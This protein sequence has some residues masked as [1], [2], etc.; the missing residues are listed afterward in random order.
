VASTKTVGA[1]S[2][3]ACTNLAADA[4]HARDWAAHH[5]VPLPATDNHGTGGEILFYLSVGPELYESIIQNIGAAQLGKGPRRWCSAETNL[6]LDSASSSRSPLARPAERGE[7]EPR[8]WAA[9]FDDE[10]C[11]ASITT[12][13]KRRC[14]NLLV[15]RFANLLF[16]RCGTG[17]TS[18]TYKSRQPRPWAW[19]V[20]PPTTIPPGPCADMI[21]SHLL[22]LM[23][24]VAMEPPHLG[25]AP[26]DLRSEQRHVLEA[27]RPISPDEV[28]RVAVRAQY[29]RAQTDGAVA[30]GRIARNQ[31]AGR[32]LVRHICGTQLLHRQLAGRACP[33]SA[34]GQV[35]AAQAHPSRH[36]TSNRPRSCSTTSTAATS[37]RAQTAWSSTVQP[38]RHQPALRRQ[39]SPAWA[40][41]IQSAVLDSTIAS[42]SAPKTVR[43]LCD[44]AAGA[45]HGTSRTT[46]IVMRS[47]PAWRIVIAVLD[48]WRDIRAKAWS[49]YPAEVGT[50]RGR[51][52]DPATR[53]LAQPGDHGGR[54]DASRRLARFRLAA[55]SAPDDL[56]D[57]AAGW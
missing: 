26:S 48:Y 21:Q 54:R 53:A 35:H 42:N 34:H 55:M 40:M 50:C 39:S 5:P 45:I 7:L 4:A 41:H 49:P 18:I 28:P 33:S 56:R 12:W 14:R 20:A 37:D 15:F 17:C 6:R 24:V 27:V 47:R 32:Q 30:P 9:F 10:E 22:Q 25:S 13:A 31:R 46:R 2:P 36:Q 43:G 52:A 19:A 29:T 23:A 51:R 11:S 38:T 16:D 57:C 44:A 3:A 1:P 8:S